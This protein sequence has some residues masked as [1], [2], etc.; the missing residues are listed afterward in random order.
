MRQAKKQRAKARRSERKR[1]EQQGAAEG[2]KA[3][4]SKQEVTAEE[5][6]SP[7]LNPT[8]ASF[9][10][11]TAT[12][13]NLFPSTSTTPRAI[14]SGIHTQQQM[15]AA[16]CQLQSCSNVTSPDDGATVA[17]PACGVNS[18]V[19]YCSK[20]HLY[21]DIRVHY[22]HHCC[23]FPVEI[24]DKSLTAPLLLRQPRPYFV[25][26]P[27]TNIGTIEHH[28]QAVY[29]AMEGNGGGDYF[30]FADIAVLGSILKPSEQQLLRCRGTGKLVARVHIP[31]NDDTHDTRR[32][33]LQWLAVRCLM[34]GASCIASARDC[35]DLATIIRQELI[36]Q[37][38]WDDDIITYLAMGFKQEFGM[39]L[40]VELMQ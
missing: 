16:F 15:G 26:V 24:K 28:R 8:A 5:V 31:N 22:L 25:N 1:E 6:T 27:G 7:P 37:E 11:S 14:L 17:C 40:P 36:N 29:Y 4:F 19:R 30:I 33:R 10:P 2:G 38:K 13:T 34:R 20:A 18:S 32:Q 21:E 12:P 9:E 3:T 35:I 23:R 39:Q